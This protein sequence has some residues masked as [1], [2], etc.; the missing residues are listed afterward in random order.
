MMVPT[1]VRM[2]KHA[3]ALTER[4]D[5]AVKHA[6]GRCSRTGCNESS[7]PGRNPKDHD[8]A[9]CV[10]CRN[11]CRREAVGL[12]KFGRS[13]CNNA[14]CVQLHSIQEP[15]RK[16]RTPQAGQPPRQR[17]MHP[18]QPGQQKA[19][20]LQER[21]TGERKRPASETGRGRGAPGGGRRQ[22]QDGRAADGGRSMSGE[23]TGV[24]VDPTVHDD[25]DDGEDGERRTRRQ[26]GV[27]GEGGDKAD[28]E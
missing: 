21:S 18:H 6:S 1:M 7:G 19:G 28:S 9:L 8:G 22:N 15:W 2:N 10:Q 4:L 12:A 17:G 13:G 5:A 14:E 26:G 25:M 20:D 3:W 11:V 16:T 27:D 24:M 23:D